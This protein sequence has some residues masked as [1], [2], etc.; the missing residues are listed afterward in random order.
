MSALNFQHMVTRGG[1]P[2]KI[3]LADDDEDDRFL[4]GEALKDVNPCTSLKTVNDG[5]KLMKYLGSVDGVHPDIIFLDINMP[6]KTGKEC[7]KEIRSNKELDDV[8]VV[9]FST[10]NHEK[11][12][13]ETFKN[14]ANLYVAKPVFFNDEVNILRKI[15][16]LNWQEDLLKPDKKRFVLHAGKI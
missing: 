1:E 7:L 15:F 4:F 16:S 5:D 8:P 13:D 11:D 2:I 14:G 12:I 6:C 3:L 9:M 10:S